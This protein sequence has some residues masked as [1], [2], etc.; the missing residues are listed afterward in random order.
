MICNAFL[1]NFWY[2]AGDGTCGC[3][4][5]KKRTPLQNVLQLS[6]ANELTD[7][8]YKIE[9]ELYNCDNIFNQTTNLEH[10]HHK[11]TRGQKFNLPHMKTIED[12]LKCSHCGIKLSNKFNLDRHTKN[13]C[14]AN[15]NI[16]K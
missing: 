10:W 3:L 1:I 9:H 2:Y 13:H 14:K 16:N 4:E 11:N 7:K 6:F 12:P 15:I 5:N 8:F